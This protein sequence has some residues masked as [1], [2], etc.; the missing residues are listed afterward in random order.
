[1]KKLI[2][3]RNSRTRMILLCLVDILTLTVHPFLAIIMRYEMHY[4]WVPAD[5]LHS[6]R[7][8]LII[9]IA[10]TLIIFLIL[11]LYN[12]IWSFAGM[13][14][15][16]LIVIACGLS[17]VLQA[18]GMQIL[19]LSVP[20]SFHVFYFFLLTMTTTITRFS[21]KALRAIKSSWK[22]Q[23]GHVYQTLVIGAGEAGSMIIQELKFSSHLNSRVVGV[24]NDNP[25]K[26]GKYIHGV[27]V[28]GNRDMIIPVVEKY[29]VDEIILAIQQVRRQQE[30]S[31][32]SAIR[33]RV[34]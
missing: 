13:N 15:L 1:M 17:T 6:I 21:Y 32:K 8:Y 16:A 29:G 11:N 4:S 34:N 25:S 22:K 2:N 33:H 14:E 26:K 27:K 20:R 30:R 9:N 12:S 28:L 23:S 24:I 31:L 5:Y 19:A 3:F 7:S 10:T 18:F